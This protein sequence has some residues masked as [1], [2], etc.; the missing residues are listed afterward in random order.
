MLLRN[1][2]KSSKGVQHR[3]LIPISVSI[4][5]WFGLVWWTFAHLRYLNLKKSKNCLEGRIFFHRQWLPRSSGGL[6]SDW[7]TG[8]RCVPWNTLGHHQMET[9][10]A[11]LVLCEGNHWSPVVSSHKGQRHGALM[12]SLICAWT[13]GWANNRDAGDLRRHFA[14]TCGM[15]R[16]SNLPE[17]QKT[18]VSDNA[19]FVRYG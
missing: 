2:G 11:S 10:S 17:H 7:L 12:F 8:R 4:F 5:N 16:N 13:N 15:L 14:E 6:Q 3:G 18:D 19:F 9:F 1:I